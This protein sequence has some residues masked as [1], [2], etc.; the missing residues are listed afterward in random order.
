MQPGDT[1]QVGPIQFE[2]A[3]GR[4]SRSTGDDDIFGWLSESDTATDL[5]NSSDTTIVK[6][7]QLPPVA[8][9]PAPKPK[10]KSV[11]DEARDIIRRH[12]ESLKE[13]EK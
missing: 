13:N 11:A 3:G 2:L 1:L 12:R 9:A 6:L 7:P 8:P 10:F 4:P 5:P